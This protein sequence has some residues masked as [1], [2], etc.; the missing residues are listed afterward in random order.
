[1]VSPWIC[2]QILLSSSPPRVTVRRGRVAPAVTRAALYRQGHVPSAPGGQGPSG[3]GAP[4][5]ETGK[6]APRVAGFHVAALLGRHGSGS[7]PANIWPGI[8]AA[9]KAHASAFKPPPEVEGPPRKAQHRLQRARRARVPCFESSRTAP[10]AEPSALPLCWGKCGTTVNVLP[11]GAQKASE[12]P[13][14][15]S[16]VWGPPCLA[17]AGASLAQCWLVERTNE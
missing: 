2:S 13:G 14:C 8:W 3:E 6:S 11:G 16:A 7:L 10:S 12:G 15:A 5:A 17:G 4:G 1:M 9:E